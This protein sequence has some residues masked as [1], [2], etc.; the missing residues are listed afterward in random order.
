MTNYKTLMKEI[1][2]GTNRWRDISCSWIRKINYEITVVPK[3]VYRF[4]AVLIRF[5]VFFDDSHSDRCEV[6]SIAVLICISLTISDAEHHFMCL[7]AIYMILL[8]LLVN[9]ASGPLPIY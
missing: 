1:K 4:S 9:V 3:A 5:V 8:L 6:V 7:V 2:D